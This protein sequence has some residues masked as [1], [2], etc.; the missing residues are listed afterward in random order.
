MFVFKSTMAYLARTKRANISKI[1]S[2]KLYQASMGHFRYCLLILG[3]VE[4]TKLHT[5]KRIFR[6]LTMK[7]F[8][9]VDQFMTSIMNKVNQSK[10]HGE[11]IVD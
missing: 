2:R 8:E 7:D 11:D 3:K 6:N 4:T 10:A 9:Y 1:C 5:Y